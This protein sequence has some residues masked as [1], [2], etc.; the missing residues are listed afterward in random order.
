MPPC[1]TPLK[2]ANSGAH[3]SVIT[4]SGTN[5]LHGEVYEKFQNSAMNAAPFFYNADPTITTKVPFLNRNQFGATLGGP[6]KTGQALLFLFLS[7]RAHRRC[8]GC[9]QKP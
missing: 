3:I 6:I 1:T 4:K 5:G 8:D 7:R 9:N 2:G